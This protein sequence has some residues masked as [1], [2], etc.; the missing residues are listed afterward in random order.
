MSKMADLVTEIQ[1]LYINGYDPEEISL[2][3]EV[4]TSWVFE[5]LSL[6]DEPSEAECN[7][8]DYGKELAKCC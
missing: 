4:P 7:A 2:M 3:C 6:N 5:A 1:D 8:F